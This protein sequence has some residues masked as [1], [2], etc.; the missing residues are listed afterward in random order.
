[1]GRI[2][3]LLLIFT[4]LFIKG[5]F[6]FAALVANAISQDGDALF[7]LIAMDK[8]SSVWATII[9]TIPALIIGIALY[10]LEVKT[11]IFDG[12]KVA[13]QYMIPVVFG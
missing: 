7:P 4:A 6:P 10:Y 13:L 9:T 1:M 3:F 2:V 8:K 5:W 12:L 11:G